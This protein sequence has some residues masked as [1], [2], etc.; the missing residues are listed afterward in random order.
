MKWI[1]KN[2]DCHKQKIIDYDLFPHFKTFLLELKKKK[3]TQEEFN[4][5][6]RSELM[7]HYWSRCQYELIIERNEEGRIY[8]IPLVG[9]YDEKTA[10]IDVTDDK[11][12]DWCGFADK[13]IKSQI[14]G[15]KA[16]IDI[17]NQVEYRFD[18]FVS[19]CWDGIYKR[20][21]PKKTGEVDE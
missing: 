20:K 6:I 14:F 8:L 21:S 19:Y 3:K 4:K 11:T 15:D 7:Y 9:C 12:F 10:T 2:F 18:E 13:H 5:A 1:V 17:W 16:K